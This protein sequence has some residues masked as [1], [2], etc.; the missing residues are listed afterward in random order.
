RPHTSG[1]HGQLIHD[2]FLTRPPT[3]G[4]P[5]GPSPSWPESLAAPRRSRLDLAVAT[6]DQYLERALAVLGR[7]VESRRN[8]FTQSGY[9]SNSRWRLR[10]MGPGHLGRNIWLGP[11]DVG[12]RRTWRGQA[13]RSLQASATMLA[14]DAAGNS[15]DRTVFDFRLSG[16]R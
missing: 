12:Y 2:C 4:P 11:I 16:R 7:L 13:I 10:S 1:A 9:E 14:M 6:Q 3:I 15:I 8:R 5:V